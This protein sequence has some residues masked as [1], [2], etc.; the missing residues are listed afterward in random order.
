[1]ERRFEDRKDMAIVL[2]L[3]MAGYFVVT[4]HIPLTP[5]NNLSPDRPQL[6]STVVGTFPALLVVLA[7]LADR[8]LPV[9]A[10]W[11]W[12]WLLLQVRQWWIPYF[13]GSTRLHRD[14]R[15]YFA[16]RYNRTLNVLNQKEDR[17]VPDVQ[18]LVLQL[19]TMLSALAVTLRAI[20]CSH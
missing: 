6:R 17:P 15:W 14:L 20:G 5:F 13:F 3:V 4:N 19:L 10:S 9:A 11:L 16:G 7:L 18:H 8:G 2:V 12:V 1:M